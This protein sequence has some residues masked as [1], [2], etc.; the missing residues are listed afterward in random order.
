MHRNRVY[1]FT[2][3]INKLLK[4]SYVIAMVGLVFAQYASAMPTDDDLTPHSSSEYFVPAPLEPQL[5]SDGKTLYNAVL[6]VVYVADPNPSHEPLRIQAPFDL[7][8]LPP[9]SATATFSITYVPDLGTDLWGQRCYTFPDEAKTAIDAAANIWANIL[10]SSVP[11]TIRACWASLTG[12][13][14]GYSGGG[15]VHSDFPGAPLANTFYAGSLANALSGYDLSTNYDMHITYNL[16]FSWYYGTDG[17]TPGSEYDLMSVVLHETAH[18]LNFSGSMS[19][20]GGSGSWGYGY[21]IPNIYDTFVRDGSGNQLISF[22]TNPS[23]P[24]GTALTSNNIYFHGSNAMAANSGQ[25]VKI[26]APGTWAQGSSYSHLDYSTFSGSPNRL[27]VFAISAGDSIHDPGPVTEGI[28]EDLGWSI[29]TSPCTY[30]IDPENSP[31]FSP[32]GGSGSFN[33][34]TQ[35]GCPWTATESLDWVAITSDDGGTGSGTVTYTVSSNA[36]AERS[37]TITISGESFTGTHTITQAGPGATNLFQNPG[38]ESGNTVWVQESGPQPIISQSSGTPVPAYTGNWLA[39]FGG[40]ENANDVLYQQVTIPS[41]ACQ[42]NVQFW[43]W[44][45]TE[46]TSGQNDILSVEIRRNSDNALLKTLK[47]LSNLDS[48]S[49]WVQSQQFDVTEFI[50][51][52][53]RLRFAA[54]TNATNNTNFFIDDVN[55]MVMSPENMIYVKGDGACAGNE[56]CYSSIQSAVNGANTCTIINATGDTYN[57]NVVLSILKHLILQGGWDSTFTTIQSNTTMRSL[58]IAKGKLTAGNIILR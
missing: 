40:Y 22:Y 30:S 56:P 17:S 12:G 10:Q 11:I 7:L 35:S 24:L 8:T 15:P 1:C 33:I 28:L 53:V 58:T 20:S 32:S 41:W 19:Y 29:S 27:M 46:E 2:K 47:T 16:N 5:S 3:M 43:Y 14:L 42:A 36:G 45:A 18:G 25:R 34:T 13:T 23:T 51:Q 6:P 9:E 39:W 37:G 57:E 55:L 44:I 52:T 4:L 26:Y 48:T 21:G 38:F 49:G 31:L 54:T 50:G